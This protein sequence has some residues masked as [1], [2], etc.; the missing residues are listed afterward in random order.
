MV[1]ELQKAEKFIFLEYFIVEEGYMWNTILEILK[2]KVRE[3]VEVRFM[4]DGMCSISKLPYDYPR[5]MRKYGIRCKMFSPIRPVLTTVQN[6][7]DHRKICVVD[8]KVA[9]TGGVNLADEYIN[10]IERFGYWKDT[11][12]MFE[13]DAVQSFTIMFL[14]MWNATERGRRILSGLSDGKINRS[15]ET[16]TGLCVALCGQSV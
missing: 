7:R 2:A 1:R 12:V 13:G 8:G 3:G 16:G 10:R 5:Q 14:Q 4:Y 15:E 11:A 6:N 9:F